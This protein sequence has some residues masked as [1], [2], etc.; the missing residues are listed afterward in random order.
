MTRIAREGLICTLGALVLITISELVRLVLQRPFHRG[1]FMA[2]L[3]MAFVMSGVVL[4]FQH[5]FREKPVI[6]S[7]VVASIMLFGN[8]IAFGSGIDRWTRPLA[9]AIGVF[10]ASPVTYAVRRR[11]G[12]SA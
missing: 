11:S 9:L 6:V 8:A 3:A 4:A 12:F 7:A 2:D 5:V 10:V 1:L